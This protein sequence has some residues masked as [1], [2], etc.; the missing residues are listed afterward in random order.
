VVPESLSN[1]KFA[2]AWAEWVEYR[3]EAGVEHGWP[4][5][6]RSF[7]KALDKCEKWGVMR[8]IA[9]IDFSIEMGYRGLFEPR[10]PTNQN[11]PSGLKKG[12]NEPKIIPRL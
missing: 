1:E 4:V 12:L 6:V 7:R 8:S 9:A 11:Q 10:Y 3:L 2:N 5:N